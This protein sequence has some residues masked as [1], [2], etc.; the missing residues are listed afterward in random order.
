VLFLGMR[1][2]M[3][4]GGSCASGGPYVVANTCPKGIWMVPVSIWVGLMGVG[5]YSVAVM[6]FPGPRWGLLAWPALFI[7]L[8]WNFWEYALDPPGDADGPVIGWLICGVVFVVM[9]GGPL[10]AGLATPAG[11]RHLVWADVEPEP[12]RP[13]VRAVAAAAS[14]LQGRRLRH[15]A[16]PPASAATPP[17]PPPTSMGP[18]GDGDGG[19]DELTD[20]L[21][22]LSR[23]YRR[24]DLTA[25]EFSAAKAR[26]IGGR[27]GA[28]P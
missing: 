20:A 28:A 6:R 14:P 25:E 10:V 19:A 11:R 16:A 9:G 4:I 1:S 3:E 7:S 27:T 2:V 21:E 22:R 26:L 8:G 15:G 12:V 18:T 23:M 13:T 17:P 24:G 5:V